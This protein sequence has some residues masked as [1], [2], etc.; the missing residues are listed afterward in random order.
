MNDVAVEL[1]IQALGN[2]LLAHYVF[3]DSWFSSL[4]MFYTLKQRG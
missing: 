3:F 2:H 4:R 1:L